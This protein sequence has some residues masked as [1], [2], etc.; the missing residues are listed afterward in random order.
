M[1]YQEEQLVSNDTHVHASTTNDETGRL[2]PVTDNA[3]NAIVVGNSSEGVGGQP[4]T[5]QRAS[6][7]GERKPPFPNYE[8]DTD[9]PWQVLPET[10]RGAV[11]EMCEND[12]L[13]LPLAVQ[14]T[15][16]AVSIVCQDLILVDRGFGEPTVCSLFMLAVADTGARKTRADRLVT[17]S[18]ES[19][20]RAQEA[21][22]ARAEV[23]YENEQKAR[24][25]KESALERTYTGLMRKTYH[26][27]P[28]TAERARTSLK[29]VEKL[30]DELST[31]PLAFPKPRLKRSLYSS[32]SIRDLERS[33]CENWAAAGLASNDAADIL[34]ARSGS[35][36]ARLCRLWDGQGIDVVGRTVRESFSISD[37]R[38]TMSLMIQPFIFDS[39]IQRK[40]EQAKGIG[41][42]PRMLISR[43]DTPYGQRRTDHTVKASTVWI[44]RLNRRLLAL[45]SRTHADIEQ[46]AQSRKVL[47]F[48]PAA[49]KLWDA[50][51]NEK[52][53][54]TADG[55]RY[56][57]ER[58]FVNRYSEHVA[59][60]A[61]LFQFFE[62]YWQA[63]DRHAGQLE[64]SEHTLSAAIQ[65][66]EWY[67]KEFGRIFNPDMSLE[68]AAKYA[69]KKFKE[70]LAVKNG[71]Q[72]PDS[73]TLSYL[74]IE[75]P[76]NQLRLYC[77]GFG[78]K[79]DTAK[80]KLAM[81]WLESRQQVYRYP[82]P[83]MAT[84]KSTDTVRLVIETPNWLP[85]DWRRSK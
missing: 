42:I 34:D 65:V 49:Q 80:F 71:G 52:E 1:N 36:M 17:P 44:E 59:R 53:S 15:L 56:V 60:L 81:D 48:S 78:L 70:R 75:L 13:A 41:F 14:S 82:K 54:Q 73:P 72:V 2:E 61:A 7:A 83:D 20:D 26:T 62:T 50:D 31:Q 3:G 57:H 24:R 74:N 9:F 28:E 51:Y 85:S 4:S 12:K 5:G 27:D 63:D 30:L 68:E 43:P 21:K 76:E 22:Y 35:D 55:G 33:L 39:F 11:L 79:G 6:Q 16:S 37:P 18:I 67:L 58:E 47:S 64:I 29:D 84:G 40:G 69:L 10:V 77:P 19:Y 32:I 46:R 45:L 38:L 66:C 23:A 8:P 25:L